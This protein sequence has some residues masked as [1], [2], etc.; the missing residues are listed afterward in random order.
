MLEI[1]LRFPHSYEVQELAEL[2][3]TGKLSFPLIFFPPPLTR[4]EHDGL[5][6]TVKPANG[7]QWIG[8]FKFGYTSPPAFSRVISSP[9]P[10]RV[11]VIANGAAYLVNADIAEEWERIPIIP[12]LD[13]RQLPEHGLLIFSDFTALAAYSSAG[14]LWRSPRVCWD[15]LKIVRVTD[16]TIEG[17]GDDPTNSTTHESRFVVDLKSGRSLLPSP[18]STDGKSVW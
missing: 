3:G 4:P 11:C 6:I 5:W 10:S 7:K 1:D 14:F 18:R 2:P 16:N 9:D 15:G 17:I 8:D 12:V 13:L